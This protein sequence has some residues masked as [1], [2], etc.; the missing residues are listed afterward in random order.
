M[1]KYSLGF[2]KLMN[3]KHIWWESHKKKKK[4][5]SLSFS[6]AFL[7]GSA[8]T[9]EVFS[10]PAASLRILAELH[11]GTRY[12]VEGKC[13]SFFFFFSLPSQKR[14]GKTLKLSHFT[15]TR[16]TSHQSV[17]WILISHASV[18]DNCH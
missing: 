1:N 4:D 8:V 13:F 10:S 5:F 12:G 18:G 16:P 14:P 2:D 17:T 9:V 3:G 7:L 11:I 15:L 6:S